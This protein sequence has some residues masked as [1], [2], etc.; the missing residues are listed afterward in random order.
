MQTSNHNFVIKSIHGEGEFSGYASIFNSVDHY[1]DV[2]LPGAFRESLANA[3][4]IQLLW[5]HDPKEPIGS[6]QVIKET[7]KGLY[8]EGRLILGL[9]RAQEVYLLL[10][11]GIVTGLSIG[12]E[13]KES[14]R[15][16]DIRYIKALKLWEISLVTFPANEQARV[17][18]VKDGLTDLKK[19]LKQAQRTLR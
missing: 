3:K 18:E 9:K 13:I 15:A 11:K 16:Q 17:G 4:Q 10:Q 14:F 6:L 8:V 19:A 1:D 5:Q 7:V 12:F 2:I